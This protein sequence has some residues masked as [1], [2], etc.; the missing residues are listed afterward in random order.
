MKPLKNKLKIRPLTFLLVICYAAL[1]YQLCRN[2]DSYTE[3]KKDIQNAIA[4]PNYHPVLIVT[5]GFEGF[6]RADK[7][8]AHD[9]AR[10]Y[11]VICEKFYP[12]LLLN[13]YLYPEREM[14]MA[15]NTQLD[16][17]RKWL[18]KKDLFVEHVPPENY[19]KVIKVTGKDASLLDKQERKR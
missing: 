14:R 17:I 6:A 3:R 13:F 7:L 19:D 12:P 15:V 11:W 18:C 4:H 8:I 9:S 2:F 1:L 5:R 16:I 10:Q